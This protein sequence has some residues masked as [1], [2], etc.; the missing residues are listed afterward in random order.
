MVRP[1][2]VATIIGICQADPFPMLDAS[3]TT[4][5][6][7]GEASLTGTVP[8]Q[9]GTLTGVTF[10]DVGKN[11][12]TGTLPSEFGRLSQIIHTRHA[13]GAGSHFFNYNELS[14]TIPTELGNLEHPFVICE[15]L[16]NGTIPTEL[17]RMGTHFALSYNSLSGKLPTQLGNLVKVDNGFYTKGNPELC[18]SIPSEVAALSNLVSTDWQISSF[19]S[20]G[21][22]C[23]GV[24]TPAP[25]VGCEWGQEQD[26]ENGGH[27]KMC[28]PGRVSSADFSRCEACVA[29][30]GK[31]PNDNFVQDYESQCAA[32]YVVGIWTRRIGFSHTRSSPGT[33]PTL[34]YDGCT[35][36][37][38]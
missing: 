11:K 26:F 8:T 27:C 16:F 20:L 33:P 21:T 22:P 35:H 18:G 37:L 1:W 4:D 13:G 29:G 30:K 17:G 3:T 34:R 14:G 24:P 25:T 5:I 28:S 23:R 10:F 2:I 31:Q 32:W 38:L 19:T 36:T 9:I 6:D 12:L 7:Y 15:N